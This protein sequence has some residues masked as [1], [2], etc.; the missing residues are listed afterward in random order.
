MLVEFSEVND[1]STFDEADS[2][3]ATFSLYQDGRKFLEA[4]F[5]FMPFHTTEITPLVGATSFCIAATVT[6][7]VTIVQIPFAFLTLF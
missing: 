5:L 3:F 1:T 2:V 4:S 6:I 7:R